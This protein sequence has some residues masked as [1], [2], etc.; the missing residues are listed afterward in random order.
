MR[1][2]VIKKIHKKILSEAEDMF[3][4]SGRAWPGTLN[5]HPSVNRIVQ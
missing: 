3:Q 5:F 2:G 4:I 1:I